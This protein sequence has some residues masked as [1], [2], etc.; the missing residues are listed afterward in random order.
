MFLM[1]LLGEKS[2]FKNNNIFVKILEKWLGGVRLKY[3]YV[4]LVRI[5][6]IIFFC[7]FLGF[8]SFFDWVC[9]IFLIWKKNKC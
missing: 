1:Y 4:W 2:M 7:D 6:I 3:Y 9:I 5:W 8:L